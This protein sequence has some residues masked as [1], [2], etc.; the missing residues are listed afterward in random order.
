M[1]TAPPPGFVRVASTSDL[2]DGEMKQVS[3]DG[4]DVLLA[5]AGGRFHACTAFCTHYG[6]PLADG[7]LCG[8]T[9]VCPWHHAMFDVATGTLEAPPALDRLRAF[10]VRV[11]GEDVFVRA[12]ADAGAH[13]EDVPYRVSDGAPA[14]SPPEGGREGAGSPDDRTFVLVGGGAAA[15]AAAEALREFGFRGRILMLSADAHPPYDR[16]KLSKGVLA[17]KAGPDAL[18]LRDAAFYRRLRID[19][20][21][22]AQVTALD[23][24]ARLLTLAGGET[25]AYDAC[26]VAP[27]G[28][29]RRLPVPGADRDGVF[30]LRSRE[31]AGRLVAEAEGA[32]RVVVVGTGFIGMEAASSLCDRGLDVTVIGQD[33]VP[34]ARVLGEQVGRVFQEAAEGKGVRFC[35]GATVEKIEPAEGD[36]LRVVLE[37]GDAAEGDLVLL[38]VGVRPAT[39]FLEGQ[40]FRRGDDGALEADAHLRLADGLYA[41]G[42]AVR[43]PEARLGAPVR[44]EHW[45]LAQQH[46]RHAARAMLGHAAPFEEVPFFWTGQFGLGLRYVGHAEDFDEVVVDGDLGARTFVAF[47]VRQGRAV[48]AAAVGRDRDAAAFHVLLMRDAVPAPDALRSGVDLQALAARRCGS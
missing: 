6:A 28:T 9:V 17:G 33:A 38:G 42:D 5:R 41:A 21:T 23:P 40:P 35:L 14:A 22:G 3:A 48:A 19:V 26:L 43:Y 30:L 1:A 7:L 44:I 18:P 34:F 10:E 11:E 46:G 13:G 8:T 39:D 31:D 4:T 24:A 12:P 36:G 29:P 32:R 20:Q 45:R 25:V 27:G 37:G 15:Q 47:Y 2:A 16:T